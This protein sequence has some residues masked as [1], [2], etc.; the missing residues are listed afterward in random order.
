MVELVVL[1]AI[2]TVISSV[3]LASFPVLSRRIHLQRSARQVALSLRKAQNMA[4]AVRQANTVSGRVIPPAYGV[5]FSRT[6]P[7][8]YL[9]FADLRGGPGGTADGIYSPATDAVVET[10]TLDPGIRIANLLADLSAPQDAI[11][12][13]FS[14]PEARMSIASPTLPLTESL[15][16]VLQV[17]AGSTLPAGAPNL[18]RSV[19]VRTSGQIRVQ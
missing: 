10:I 8:S 5:H 12:V 7:T 9:V 2:I 19:I 15:E 1:L 11:S 13:A 16:V 17:E 14:V 3:V 6:A 18:T 4:F